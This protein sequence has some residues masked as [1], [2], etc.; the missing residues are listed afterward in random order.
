MVAA[1]V[2]K[3]PQ[4]TILGTAIGPWVPRRSLPDLHLDVETHLGHTKQIQVRS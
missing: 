1:E 2:L 4:E 3:S